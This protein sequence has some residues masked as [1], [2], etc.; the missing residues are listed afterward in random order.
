MPTDILPRGKQTITRP[1]RRWK[2]NIRI[3]L[4]RIGVNTGNWDD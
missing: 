4:K 1:R 3:D 2:E